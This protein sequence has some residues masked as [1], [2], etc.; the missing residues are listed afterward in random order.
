MRRIHGEEMRRG[1]IIPFRREDPVQVFAVTP[2]TLWW[3]T[4]VV[5]TYFA[6]FYIPFDIAFSDIAGALPPTQRCAVHAAVI[7]EPGARPDQHYLSCSTDDSL[8]KR[9]YRS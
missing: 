4:T 5:A 1:V 7:Q 3:F 9:R 6:V 8:Q 2:Y